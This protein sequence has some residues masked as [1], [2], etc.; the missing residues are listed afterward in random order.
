MA[1]LFSINCC[2]KHI[3]S[4]F[5]IHGIMEVPFNSAK[6]QLL[7]GRM[8]RRSSEPPAEGAVQLQP[9]ADVEKATEKSGLWVAWSMY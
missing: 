8:R 4:H 5:I 6:A 9:E 3:T 1:F 2:D 7:E